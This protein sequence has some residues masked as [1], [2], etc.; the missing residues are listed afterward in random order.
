MPVV[1]EFILE[2]VTNISM[3]TEIDNVNEFEE[4]LCLD[5]DARRSG[6]ASKERPADAADRGSDRSEGRPRLTARV[7]E[8][9]DA[10]RILRQS[11]DALHRARLPRP[12]RA[13]P[14][15]M[16]SAASSIMFP[17]A[18]PKETARAR[19]AAATGL[20]RCCTTCRPATGTA[21]ERGIA[22]LPDRGTSSGTAWAGVEYATALGCRQRE[23]PRRH[24]A[25]GVDAPSACA[26]TFVENLRFAAPELK[27]GRHPA[28]DR[29]GQHAATSRASA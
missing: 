2:R 28:A 26:R 9:R 13:R 23:L 12:L 11:H 3:G 18:F 19:L 21:G 6:S 15:P 25:A 7:G 17:Y 22:C 5:P 1:L 4:I 29:G 8:Q 14:R 27:R 16:A 24:P 20:P 10:C